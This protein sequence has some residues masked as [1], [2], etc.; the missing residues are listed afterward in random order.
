MWMA[1]DGS[2]PIVGSESDD[3]PGEVMLFLLRF[4][5]EEVGYDYVHWL[6][7]RSERAEKAIRALSDP[8]IANKLKEEYLEFVA[9]YIENVGSYKVLYSTI[10][11][12]WVDTEGE[13]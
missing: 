6:D 12:E 7:M 4:V 5:P 9:I 13:E 10:S 1:F 8:S 11:I 3:D 2:E